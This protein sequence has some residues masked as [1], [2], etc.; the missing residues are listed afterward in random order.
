MRFC[1]PRTG[2]WRDWR[3]TCDL[4][5]KTLKK[6]KGPPYEVD[7]N[8]YKQC[9]DELL[10]AYSGKCAYC[11]GRLGAQS[12]P[13]VEH[14]RPKGG[15]RDLK[16]KV[17]NVR[18]KKPHTGYWWL[19]YEPSNLLPACS[20]CNV[21]SIKT[22][23]KGERFPLPEGGFR[24]AKPDEEKKEKPLLIHPGRE[25]PSRFLDLELKTGML[26]AHGTRGQVSIEVYGLNREALIKDRKEEWMNAVAFITLFR[27]KRNPP[28]EEREHLDEYLAG[29]KPYSLVWKKVSEQMAANR[30][31]RPAKK[32][33]R[34]RA[35]R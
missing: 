10:A 3:K 19:A 2:R 11:E 24:A 29:R 7:E 23:G 35:S 30:P 14:F 13:Q 12:S 16:N 17:V 20:E 1:K 21:Y 9:R 34:S 5:L 6:Q 4:K 28:R 32:R 25:D 18:P 22:G 26:M 15:V 27:R 33:S 8:L 31:A